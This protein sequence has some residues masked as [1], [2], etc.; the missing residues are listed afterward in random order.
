M[1][2]KQ[3]HT[4]T[5]WILYAL[6]LFIL[7]LS[8]AALWLSQ[9]F[10]STQYTHWQYL[11][12]Q[13]AYAAANSGIETARL[14]LDNLDLTQQ[15]TCSNLSNALQSYP[16]A[17]AASWQYQ[18]GSTNY[19]L[20]TTLTSTVAP[21]STSIPVNSTQGFAS[22]GL[23]KM[24]TEIIA[25]YRIVGN[26]FQNLIRGLNNT[27][28]ATHAMGIPVVQPAAWSPQRDLLPPTM[29]HSTASVSSP[30]NAALR[31]RLLSVIGIMHLPLPLGVGVAA[32]P[33]SVRQLTRLATHVV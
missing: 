23:V 18:L 5:G 21:N 28:V 25:Y 30:G 19:A 12:T 7:L 17:S 29:I 33:G 20:S 13:Q 27:P 1:H 16:S 32:G 6:V 9:S 15:Q 26:S 11:Q 22:V 10:D 24:D 4:Q 14:A 3:R 8:G 31:S 2:A